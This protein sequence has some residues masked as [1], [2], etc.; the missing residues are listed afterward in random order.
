[1]QKFNPSDEEIAL[2]EILV[3]KVISLN[4]DGCLDASLE[5]EEN[6]VSLFAY[7]GQGGVGWNNCILA[8][9]NEDLRAMYKWLCE[10]EEKTIEKTI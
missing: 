1:M 4:V 6:G 5:I 2:I 8:T 3:K 9:T 10:E 7:R